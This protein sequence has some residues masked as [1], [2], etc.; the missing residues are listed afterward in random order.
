MGASTSKSTVGPR[1]PPDWLARAVAAPTQGTTTKGRAVATRP[2][3]RSSTGQAASTLVTDKVTK[4][5][6]WSAP[7]RAR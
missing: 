1:N 5:R 3:T 6:A 4:K 7:S 2:V